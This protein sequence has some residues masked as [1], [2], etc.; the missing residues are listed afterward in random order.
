M[1]TAGL[2]HLTDSRH[3]G[4]DAVL[5]GHLGNGASLFLQNLLKPTEAGDDDESILL[6][7]LLE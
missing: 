2:L 4:I 7:L 3:P 1:A 5:N 6:H